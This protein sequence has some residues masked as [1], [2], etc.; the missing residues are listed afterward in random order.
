MVFPLSL[1]RA[2]EV[3]RIETVTG[4]FGMQK[5]LTELGLYP[6]EVVRVISS[7]RGPVVIDVKGSRVGIGYG[8]AR[9]IMVRKVS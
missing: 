8:M 2:G 3:V 6:G 7:D 9:R 5:K 4:G 1:A